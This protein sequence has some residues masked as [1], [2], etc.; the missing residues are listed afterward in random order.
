M[1]ALELQAVIDGIAPVLKAYVTDSVGE[2]LTRI[3]ALEARPLPLDGKDGAP[4]LQGPAGEPGPAGA[5]GPEGPE[6]NARDGR[7]G[8]PGVPG[9]QG[10][11]GIDGVNGTDGRDGIDGLGFDDLSVE[12]DGDRTLAL[13]FVKGLVT[14]TFPIVLPIL[15][16][17]GVYQEGKSYDVG[18]VATWAGGMW[19]CQAPTIAKPGEQSPAWKLCVS[20]GRDGKHGQNGLAGPAGRNGKDWNS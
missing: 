7:D 15:R 12:F 3:A 8:L 2:A 4:G 20:R 18:D 17:Q 13:H 1:T 6:G 16:Y 11:K 10:E 9:L 19:H 14:K 5:A